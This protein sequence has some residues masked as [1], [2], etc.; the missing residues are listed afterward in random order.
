[1]LNIDVDVYFD[2]RPLLQTYK[3][4]REEDNPED[5][6]VLRPAWEQQQRGRRPG[7]GR[8]SRSH[9]QVNRTVGYM[10]VK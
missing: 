2:W 7:R 3:R 6:G 4:E 9:T 8:G 10:A 5:P 1:M